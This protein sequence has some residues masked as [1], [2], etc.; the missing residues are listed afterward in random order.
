MSVDPRAL[1]EDSRVS[2]F[3]PEDSEVQAADLAAQQALSM[4][5]L[6]MM[7]EE[8][9]PDLM[10]TLTKRARECYDALRTARSMDSVA[11]AQGRLQELEWLLS[12]KDLEEHNLRNVIEALRNLEGGS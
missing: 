8:A 2:A 9:W 5:A 1:T 4:R 7:Q 3:P 11:R 12:L 6:R 10:Q